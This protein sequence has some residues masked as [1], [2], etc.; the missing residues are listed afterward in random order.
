MSRTNRYNPLHGLPGNPD[1]LFAADGSV[2]LPK[3]TGVAIS[4]T[5]RYPAS[6]LSRQP[7][8]ERAEAVQAAL[9]E[10]RPGLEM[11]IRPSRVRYDPETGEPWQSF[12]LYPVVA[13]PVSGL[14]SNGAALCLL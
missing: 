2:K 7:T 4:I 9:A 8:R 10:Y 14:P 3:L 1:S 11:E 12:G 5:S 6:C 13:E